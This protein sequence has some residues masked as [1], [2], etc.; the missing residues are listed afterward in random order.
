M[1]HIFHHFPPFQ[2]LFWF[3]FHF[4]Q[5][6]RFQQALVSNQILGT[7]WLGH[8]TW[9]RGQEVCLAAVQQN[10]RALRHASERQQN[11]KEV[12]DAALENCTEVGLQI[13]ES[14]RLGQKKKW[15]LVW[16]DFVI[17]GPRIVGTFG[18]TPWESQQFG[19]RKNGITSW[20]WL[21]FWPPVGSESWKDKRFSQKHPKP[22]H[23]IHEIAG[24]TSGLAICG[25]RAQEGIGSSGCPVVWCGTV[26]Q[27]NG[28]EQ[29]EHQCFLD[30]FFPQLEN[31]VLKLIKHLKNSWAPGMGG[32]PDGSL[33]RAGVPPA[34]TASRAN[35]GANQGLTGRRPW[36]PMTCT[37]LIPKFLSLSWGFWN[38][39]SWVSPKTL[40]FVK[41]QR[42]AIWMDWI[43]PW[44][45]VSCGHERC[46]HQR[47]SK[48]SGSTR[49][50]RG[51][52]SFSPQK[53]QL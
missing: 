8:M 18:P 11:N 42:L 19:W 27:K 51:S 40:P 39:S 6:N 9:R 26:Y 53:L 38:V 7:T 48:T 33:E 46:M 1:V 3:L 47:I 49:G 2:Q 22:D 13:G 14:Y 21:Q 37:K 36:A 16:W 20:L 5:L 52:L 28:V 30:P 24:M 34:A 4:K 17:F 31:W 35:P 25:S 41:S 32:N 29:V 45:F 10:G 23:E 44:L 43:A 15:T 12:V 50:I